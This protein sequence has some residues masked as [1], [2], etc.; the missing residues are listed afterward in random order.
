MN[1]PKAPPRD[2][3]GSPFSPQCTYVQLTDDGRALP[4]EVGPDFW[5]HTVNHHA[6]GRLAFA[7]HFDRNTTTWEQHPQ[8]EEL[9]YVLSGA[10]DFILELPDGEKV[11][12]LRGG[13]AYIVPRGV[14]HRQ[15]VRAPGEIFFV[16]AGK[17]TRHRPV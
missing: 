1:D 16:T 8:G 3:I 17:G 11:V 14:W 9:V 15:V 4:I 12:E 7:Y 10:V 5:S 6:E 2:P 13:E